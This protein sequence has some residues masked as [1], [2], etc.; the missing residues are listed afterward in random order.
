MKINE[1]KNKDI[2]WPATRE[3][4]KVIK[5]A[6]WASR[7]GLNAH[8]VRRVLDGS[9]PEHMPS[10]LRVVTA[11]QNDGFLKLSVDNISLAA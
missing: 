3:E 2:D 11:I 1:L 6:I 9:Y 8:T 4:M 7:K 10:F 5:I